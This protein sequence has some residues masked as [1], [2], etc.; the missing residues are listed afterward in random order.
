[1]KE[2]PL[3]PPDFGDDLRPQFGCLT[4][5]EQEEIIEGFHNDHPE[6]YNS[7]YEEAISQLPD[8]HDHFDLWEYIA[9]CIYT[10]NDE[11]EWV[12]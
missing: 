3:D 11:Q 4:E 9:G 8:N 1:M 12:I 5:A 10:A 2:Q 6:A 7:Y